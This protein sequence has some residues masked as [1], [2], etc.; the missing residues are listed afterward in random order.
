MEY[1]T[2]VLVEDLIC[3]VLMM[4]GAIVLFITLATVV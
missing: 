2:K 4:V 1:T 3:G